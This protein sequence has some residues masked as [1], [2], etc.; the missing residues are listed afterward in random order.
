[1]RVSF[2]LR[3]NRKEVRA[4]STTRETPAPPY[5]ELNLLELISTTRSIHR[6]RPDPIPDADLSGVLH[7]ATRGPSGSNAQPFRFLVLRD[8]PNAQKAKA[9]LGDSYR[10]A[11]DAKARAEGWSEGSGADPNS[12]KARSAAAMREFVENFEAVPVVILACLVHHRAATSFDGASIYPAC[13]NL[14]LAARGLG[15]G[16][17]ITVFHHAAEPALRTLL[18]IPETASV[19]AVLPLGRPRGNHGPLRRRPMRELVYEDGWDKP[20][21]WASDPPGSRFSRGGRPTRER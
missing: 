9:L 15:Y 14:V 5:E 19:C 13:Q 21:E 1:M 11:W 6:Y 7:A 12:R 10:G 8:G 4:M 17:C 20:A 16:S 18:E 2:G 3:F